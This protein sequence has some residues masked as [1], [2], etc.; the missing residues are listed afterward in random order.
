[1]LRLLFVLM[2]LSLCSAVQADVI[3]IEDFEDYQGNAGFDPLFNHSFNG[4]SWSIIDSSYYPENGEVLMLHQQTEDHVTFNL[5]PGQHITYASV[6]AWVWNSPALDN[7]YSIDFVGQNGV[8]TVFLEHTED[9]QPFGMSSEAIGYITEIR[10]HS[11]TAESFYDN[12]TIHVVPEPSCF[13]LLLIGI[14]ISCASLLR[15]IK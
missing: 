10:L 13:M 15:R 6:D 14:V 5:P 7:D 11:S 4:A 12:I 1:M 8:E 9:Y 3:Y 2:A